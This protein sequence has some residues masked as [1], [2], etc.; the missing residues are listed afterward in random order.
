[1]DRYQNVL[2]IVIG[3]K[4][5]RDQDLIVTLLTKDIGKIFAIAKG[6]K[7]IRSR[8][9]GTLQLGNQVKISLYQKDQRYW[10]NES[11]TIDSFLSEP[12]NLAQTNLLFYLLEI[13]NCLVAENQQIEGVYQKTSLAIKA[14]SQN[15][16]PQF[17]QN[18]IELLR[19]FGFGIP[20]EIDRS[21]AAKDFKTTQRLIK[22][23]TES[24]IEKPL[25]S[26]KLFR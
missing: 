6:V 1:M 13:I 8:R 19:D 16:V 12:K 4:T 10:V 5:Y 9:L 22:V 17:I 23:F 11:A 21:F 24:I 15:R 7:N 2:A 25:E 3:K 26:N 18:E 20:P 14:I